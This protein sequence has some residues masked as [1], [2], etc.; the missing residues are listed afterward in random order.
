MAFNNDTFLEEKFLE[1]RDQWGI[2]TVIETGTYYADTTKWL[3]Q[4]FETVYT[5]EIH[6]PTYKIAVEQ[7]EGIKNVVHTLQPSQEFLGEALRIAE[8]PLLVFLDA[9]WFENPLLAEIE[10]IG[11]S[12][13]RP[14]LAIHDFKV[15]GKSFGYDTYPGITYDWAYVKDSVAK[16]YGEKFRHEYNEQATGARRGC[17]F[18]YPTE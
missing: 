11:Q 12:G 2:K 5:C 10:L 18:V 17:L 9:H 15:P 7:L 16:A 1:I 3:A 6:E 8:G 13:R 4:H 14:V